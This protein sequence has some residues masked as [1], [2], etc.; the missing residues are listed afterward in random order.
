MTSSPFE[1]AGFHFHCT[2][3]FPRPQQSGRIT[4][5]NRRMGSL[6][7]LGL[8]AASRRPMLG[9]SRGSSSILPVGF[10]TLSG[11]GHWSPVRSTEG[12]PNQNEGRGREVAGTDGI[13]WRFRK[14]TEVAMHMQ[15]RAVFAPRHPLPPFGDFS[16]PWRGF[17]GVAA[18]LI[19]GGVVA[20]KTP[21]A[22]MGG[23]LSALYQ[24]GATPVLPIMVL[25]TIPVPDR[26]GP[27]PGR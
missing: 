13:P 1:G 15:G 3:D 2:V 12:R 9:A 8:T 11:L 10:L 19:G 6:G 21:G 24:R 18:A 25:R 20:V 22:R 5:L 4:R 27:R 26:K 17:T 7:S 14:P 23:Q 16:V